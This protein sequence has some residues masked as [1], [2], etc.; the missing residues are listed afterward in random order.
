MTK[1]ID[2]STSW[3]E[4]DARLPQATWGL[5]AGYYV[6]DKINVTKAMTY[7]VSNYFRIHCRCKKLIICFTPFSRTLSWLNEDS[8]ASVLCFVFYFLSQFTCSCFGTKW[9][10]KDKKFGP[11]CW[12]LMYSNIWKIL[13]SKLLNFKNIK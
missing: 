1:V 10:R 5:S 12:C 3:I 13:V 8:L 6:N 11:Q 4:G 9:H 2:V 7:F